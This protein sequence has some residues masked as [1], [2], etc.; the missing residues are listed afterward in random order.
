[1]LLLNV[2]RFAHFNL[3]LS[4]SYNYKLNMFE[5]GLKIKKKQFVDVLGTCNGHFSFLSD[6]LNIE[7]KFS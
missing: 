6:V 3:L 2:L 1:M 7:Q 5:F 4:V